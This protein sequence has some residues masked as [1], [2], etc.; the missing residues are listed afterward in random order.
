MRSPTSKP[1]KNLT[2]ALSFFAVGILFLL[3][4]LQIIQISM[5]ILKYWPAILIYL[6]IYSILKAIKNP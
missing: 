2:W 5:D 1:L 3:L 6:G 4:N